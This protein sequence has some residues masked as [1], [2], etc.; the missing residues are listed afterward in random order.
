V[1][2]WHQRFRAEIA[3]LGSGAWMLVGWLAGVLGA[4]T[5]GS[6]VAYGLA[7]VF[8]GALVWRRAIVALKARAIDMN[9]LMT[10]AVFGAAAIGEWSEGAAVT[11]LFSL[12]GYLEA[13]ALERTRHSIRD[14]MQLAPETA[15]VRRGEDIADVIPDD[16]AVGDVV[17]VR[18]GERVPLD[19]V[20][21]KGFS[22]VDESPVTGESVPV[23]KQV[24]DAVF[25]GTLNTS[26]VLDVAVSAPASGSTLA[27]MV[28]LVE[29]AQASKAPVQRLVD[30]FSRWYTPSAVGL[31]VVVALAVPLVA[32][33]RGDATPA[34]WLDWLRRGL[35]V[36]VVACPCALVISTPVSIV[37][38]ITRAGRDGVL[39]KGGAYLE[40]A[41]KIRAIAFDK[42]GTLTAGRPE[43]Q[44]VHAKDGDS[45]GLLTR[46]ASLEIDSTH[47]LA[48]AVV[49]AAEASGDFRPL[50]VSEFEELPGQG[51]SGMLGAAHTRL[52]SPAFAEEIAELPYA[53]AARIEHEESE[54]R[55]VLVFVRDAVATGIISVADEVRPDASGSVKALLEGGFEHAVMLTGDNERTAS[56]VANAVGLTEH[57]ARL[58]PS[59]KVDAVVRLKERHG[60][61]AMVGDGI[62]DAP[63][64]AAAD[65]G[66]AMGAAGSDTALETA[67]VALLSDDLGALP[68]FF[69]LSRRTV[70]IIVQNV[71]F[72]VVVK[73]VVLAL[74][75]AGR[76]TLWM[77]VFADTGVALL[78]ILNGMRLLAPKPR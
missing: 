1:L 22:A 50:P 78:V 4:P 35:V 44:L 3:V 67:D 51:V 52:V 53:I 42:T 76:A 65:V 39:V 57:M 74:A 31:A 60:L 48:R 62:N 41:A 19:G 36:L 45:A 71:A 26:G 34:L 5:P 61:V 75:L 63:A 14:L 25:A 58:L 37:S 54:G 46:A 56:S 8:G 24:G 38:A 30:R 32:L 49:R 77:A 12:G 73:I 11:F 59:Q 10:V 23:E 20:V 7:I 15:H 64:L 69:D 21:A 13:R 55:T 43:V 66:I 72:S 28:Y 9:V 27:R 68:R 6:Q 70:G 17:V 29:E 18:P 2:P 16:V 33:A 40:L 47:P